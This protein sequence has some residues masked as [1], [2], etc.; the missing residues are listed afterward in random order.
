MPP[1]QYIENDFITDNHDTLISRVAVELK[2]IK[3]DELVPFPQNCYKFLRSIPGNDRCIDCGSFDSDWASITYGILICLKCSG[4][5]RS[6][7]VHVSMI[8]NDHDDIV[9][10]MLDFLTS[11]T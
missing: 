9:N 3:K 5:H 8:I 7:G 4:R 1:Q 6:L 10:E 11:L 2:N